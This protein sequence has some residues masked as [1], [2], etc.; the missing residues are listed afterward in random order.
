MYNETSFHQFD[1]KALQHANL[2]V[3][4]KFDDRAMNFKMI[5]LLRFSL[6]ERYSR[7][8]EFLFFEFCKHSNFDEFCCVPVPLLQKLL[9]N[10]GS[11]A[12][13][14]GEYCVACTVTTI[15]E[16]LLKKC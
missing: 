9:L 12:R 5:D 16:F 10:Y 15:F 14:R 11:F 13:L 4:S 2:P 3:R 6:K 8:E 1:Q 7:I